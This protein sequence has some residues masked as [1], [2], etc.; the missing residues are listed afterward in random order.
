M[1]SD[2]VAISDKVQKSINIEFDIHNQTRI[3][4]F[5]PTSST[6]RILKDF[7][8]TVTGKTTEYSNVLVGPYGKGKSM[9][10]LVL[11][12]ILSTFDDDGLQPLL[13]K[14]GKIDPELDLMIQDYRNKNKRLLPVIINSNYDNLKQAFLLGLENSLK[15]EGLMD[16]LPETQFSNCEG[17]VRQWQQTPELAEKLSECLKQLNITPDLLLRELKQYSLEALEK[18]KQVYS[19]LSFGIEYNPLANNDPLSI[20]QLVMNDLSDSSYDGFFI[21]FD[22]FSKS[23]EGH[24]EHIAENLKIIQDFAELAN[25]STE[26]QKMFLTLIT[27]KSLHLYADSTDRVSMNSFRTVEGRFNEVQMLRSQL[28]SFQLV[29]L[30]LIK[31][32]GYESVRDRF[33]QENQNFEN[34]LDNSK[35]FDKNTEDFLKKETFPFNPAT[36]SALVALSELVAQNERTLF[37]AIVD[38][39]TNSFRSFLQSN[40]EGLYQADRLYDYFSEQ[41]AKEPTLQNIFYRA[42]SLLRL[43]ISKFE[44]RI[45]K[46]LTLILILKERSNLQPNARSISLLLLEDENEVQ[47]ELDSFVQKSYFKKNS[48]DESYDFSSNS[49]K[50]IEEALVGQLAKMKSSQDYSEAVTEILNE[51]FYL[52]NRYNL[53]HKMTRYFSSKTIF[54]DQLPMISDIDLEESQADGLLVNVIVN[55]GQKE[56]AKEKV[57]L[58]AGSNRIVFR[59]IEIEEM[60]FKKLLDRYIAMKQLRGDLLSDPG[61]NERSVLLQEIRIGLETKL[62]HALNHSCIIERTNTSLIAGNTDNLSEYLSDLCEMSFPQTPLINNEMINKHEVSSGYAKPLVNVNNAI[63][64]RELEMLT[65]R[66]SKTSPENSIYRSLYSNGEVR[67]ELGD[68]L[69]L[70]KDYFLS[71][72]DQMIPA[73][74]LIT[75]LTKEPY[76]IREGVISSLL[77]IAFSEMESLPILFFK[78]RQLPMDA[79]TLRKVVEHSENYFVRIARNSA[80][81]ENYMNSALDVLGGEVSHSF[82]LNL[83]RAMFQLR[84]M[85]SRMPV[86]VRESNEKSNPLRLS[87]PFIQLKKSLLKS[88]VN[89]YDLFAEVLPKAVS[90]N[91]EDCIQFLGI[92]N[93]EQH[94]LVSYKQEIVD[95]LTAVFGGSRASS[96]KSAYEYFLQSSSINPDRI[97]LEGTGQ[98]IKKALADGSYD[99]L[100]VLNEISH[101]ITSYGVED[102]SVDRSIELVDA[103]KHFKQELLATPEMRMDTDSVVL[104]VLPAD[105]SLSMYGEMLRDSLSGSLDEF[106]ESVSNK[107]KVQILQQLLESLIEG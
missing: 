18:F 30:S 3:A 107:E 62:R 60:D 84:K 28:E 58:F 103:M 45:I 71:S 25:R 63:L 91:F 9:L 100:E 53:Q 42:E 70:I 10:I 76:G 101:L 40:S 59:Q 19:C 52:P 11:S 39:D 32:D 69:V 36:V 56:D 38:T 64:N 78:N 27:H 104:D 96:I 88:D 46:A 7:M 57:S 55:D 43:D 8:L 4:D 80:E 85:V 12:E 51:K 37:T 23:V 29:A 2:I 95:R 14:I 83:D 65:D 106:G 16:H 93:E 15:R 92:F 67:P 94:K 97:V 44:K 49:S 99:D 22:E 6:C 1:Y 34:L 5:I 26:N 20:Y 86:L 54:L 77:A 102:W 31:K 79:L 74:K 87:I 41:I 13:D 89:S 48:F 61:K 90:G 72:K 50:E 81:L 21:I 47:N 24:T 73:E 68:V 75:T 35:L 82:Y 33:Y 66:V 17:I 98:R 105:Q